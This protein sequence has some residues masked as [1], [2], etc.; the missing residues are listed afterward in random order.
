MGR[1]TAPTQAQFQLAGQPQPGQAPVQPQQQQ[2]Q[3]GQFSDFG[4][5]PQQVR[6]QRPPQQGNF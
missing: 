5:Y 3:Q 2:V 4:N 1:P 6:Q